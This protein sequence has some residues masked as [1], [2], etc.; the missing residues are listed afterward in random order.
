MSLKRSRL[1]AILASLAV[2]SQALAAPVLRHR[3]GL[4]F[5]AQAEG[6][7]ADHVVGRLLEEIPSDKELYEKEEASA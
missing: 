2:S 6:V 3:M 7:D 1:T 5:A 4:N